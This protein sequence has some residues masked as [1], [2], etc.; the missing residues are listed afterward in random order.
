[1][2]VRASAAAP[3]WA[4]AVTLRRPGGTV[5]C[6]RCEVASSPLRRMRGLLG[7]REL[8]T[9]QGILLRPASAIHCW[10][11]R[12]AI[13][14]VFL[15]EELVVLKVAP[16]VRPWRMRSHRGAKAV[17]ELAAGEAERRGLE[18]GDRLEAEP[19]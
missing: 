6:G 15:D 9:G 4:G 14:A 13:D 11:M 17:L 8:G 18:V 3:A 7:K 16:D 19:V 10:F 12:F 1:M 2:T 5:V